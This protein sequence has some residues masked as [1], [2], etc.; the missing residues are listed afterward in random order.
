MVVRA[1]DGVLV[2]AARAGDVDAFEAL[3]RRH[4]DTIYRVALRLLGSEADAQD[5]TQETFVG[6]W[7]GLGRFRGESAVT[8]WLYRIVTNRCLNMIAARR[9]SENLDPGLPSMGDDPAEVTEKRERFA[10]VARQV[11]SLPPEQR[12]A[13]VLR[14]FEGLSYEEVAAVLALSM[15]AVKGRIHRAR[16]SVLTE[17]AAWR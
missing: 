5:A 16:L 17:T 13:L 6:A 4:Q 7:R 1:T 14:D 12:A 8:T 10:A 2:E 11:A 3:V 15:P 9:P